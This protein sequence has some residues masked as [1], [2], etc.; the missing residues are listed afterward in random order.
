VAALADDQ[1]VPA[2]D[3]LFP[4]RRKPAETEPLLE[5]TETYSGEAR[6]ITP[7]HT[8]IPITVH[9][10]H[11]R[12]EG[13]AVFDTGTFVPFAALPEVTALLGEITAIDSGDIRFDRPLTGAYSNPDLVR[14]IIETHEEAISEA[15]GPRPALGI[16]GLNIFGASNVT[17]DFG[18]GF[19]RAGGEPSQDAVSAPYSDI[20]SNIWI[21]STVNGVEGHT[22]LDSGYARSWVEQRLPEAGAFEIGGQDL[23]GLL[24]VE[25]WD[26]LDQEA[27]YS[28]VALDVIA[29][30]GTDTLQEIE[31]MIEP[32]T[33]TVHIRPND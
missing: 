28:S 18:D 10:E 24:A 30:I 19:I 5:L 2:G 32:S 12:I 29:G 16:I 20:V 17:L 22:H 23:G 3:D 1:I 4:V 33:R 8:L 21:H 9:G 14:R 31:L 7:G 26:R 13:V 15:F 27:N 11:G 25:A 6:V